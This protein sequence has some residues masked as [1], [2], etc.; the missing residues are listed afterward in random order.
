MASIT[1]DATAAQ[2]DA[3]LEEVYQQT[4]QS[5]SGEIV[6]A[7]D[8]YNLHCIKGVLVWSKICIKILQSNILLYGPLKHIYHV[9]LRYTW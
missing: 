1:R 2:V 9:Y 6:Y 8:E 5:L 3:A 7:A 4:S